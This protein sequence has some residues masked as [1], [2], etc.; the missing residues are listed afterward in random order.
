MAKSYLKAIAYRYVQNQPFWGF[1]QGGD[2]DFKGGTIMGPQ[3]FSVELDASQ[4]LVFI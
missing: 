2:V 3:G 4:H 1:G